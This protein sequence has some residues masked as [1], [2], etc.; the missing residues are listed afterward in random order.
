MAWL[1]PIRAFVCCSL[2]S[3]NIVHVVNRTEQL[4]YYSEIEILFP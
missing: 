4:R 3:E 2:V 1:Y